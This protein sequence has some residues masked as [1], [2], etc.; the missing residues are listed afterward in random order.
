MRDPSDDADGFV[1]ADRERTDRLGPTTGSNRCGRGES[2]GRNDGRR[3]GRH[4]LVV[5]RLG[6]G[7]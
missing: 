1:S 5:A 3:A 4:R 6:P 2:C 7:L